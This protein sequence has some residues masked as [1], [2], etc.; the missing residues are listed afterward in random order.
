MRLGLLPALGGSLT[1]LRRTGQE[2]RLLDGY[3]RRYVEAFDGVSYFSYAPEQLA[4]FTA[5]RRL[6]ERVS[7]FAPSGPGARARRAWAIPR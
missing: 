1:E 6:L 3:V 7:L 2:A 4:D 5:D